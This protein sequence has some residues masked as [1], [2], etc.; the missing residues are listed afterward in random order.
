MRFVKAIWRW[1]DD[2]TGIAEAIGPLMKHPIPPDTGWKY[3]FGS[4]TL[5][6]FM[7]QVVTGVALTSS[8]VPSGGDAY[9]SLKF[10]TNT[11][12]LGSVLRGMHYFGASAMVVL[13]GIHTIR[14]FLMGAYKF[15]R[16]VNWLS[17]VALLVFTLAMGFTGQLLRW[18][19]NALW[20]VVVGA[21]QAGRTPLIGDWLAQLLL[22]GQT[23]GAATLSRFFALH[24]FIF[25]ALIFGLVGFHLYLV[26]RNGISEPPKMGQ[27]VEPKTY[28][29]WYEHMLKREGEPFWPD[30]AWRDVVFSVIVIGVVLALA[31]IIGPPAIGK[32][33]DPTIVEAYPKP[34]WYLLWYFAVLA[35]LPHGT[36]GY[37]IILAPLAIGL[38]FVLL[39]FVSNRGERSP[40]RRPWAVGAV[41]VSITLIATLT[42]TGEREP[43]SPH[44]EAQPLTQQTIGVSSGAVYEG[45]HLFYAKGCE[46]CHMI[47]SQGGVRGPDLTYVGDR[48]STDELTW[49]ILNGGYNMPA[50][51]GNM[52]SDELRQLVAFLQSRQQHALPAAQR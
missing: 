39:P 8:Y 40:L 49:R 3:V 21:E 19:Q 31:V 7:I 33:P 9:D 2:R 45:A 23:I 15:P 27:V 38:A 22:A 48:L 36:E 5:V 12:P 25:P 42:V 32:P 46:Y 44:F 24:V 52:T 6:A 26:I 13:I 51:G 50:Y 16:E 35:L 17:G 47:A 18:D 28:R 10:I 30:A 37:V 11:A 4:A 41:L 34:D 43:W 20:S 29:A 1:F 14:V